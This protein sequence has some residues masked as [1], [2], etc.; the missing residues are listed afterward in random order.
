MTAYEFTHLLMSVGNRIDAQWALF[1]TAHMALF[2]AIVYVDR[3]LRGIEKAVA[4][5][6]YIVFA[7][8]NFRVAYGQQA[9]FESIVIDLTSYKELDD[10][11][12]T[13]VIAYFDNARET[14]IF[15]F[16]RRVTIFIH[17]FAGLLVLPSILF[18]GAFKQ[19]RD[20]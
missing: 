8:F 5:A 7:F 14:E 11:A 13:N 15:R 3:P 10:A 19:S 16:R 20:K 6:F 4:T 1:L 2:G 17:I 12:R 9:L 18:D